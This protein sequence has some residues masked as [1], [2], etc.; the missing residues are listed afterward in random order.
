MDRLD[1]QLLQFETQGFVHLPGVIPPELVARVK[2]AF[3]AGAERHH[4]EWEKLP[5]ERRA[6]SSYYDIPDILDEDDAFVDLAD[7]SSIMP[8][9]LKAVGQDIQLNHTHA[10]IMFPGKTFTAAWHSDLEQLIGVDLAHSPHF[11]AKVHFYF[12]DL[13]PEQGCLGFLPGT[14]F[15][16]ATVN[17]RPDPDKVGGSHAAVRIVPKAGDAVLFN[18]H[19]RHM[20]FDNRTNKPRKSL[21][22]AYSH[23]WLKNYANAVPRD[24][25]RVATTPLRQQLFGVE[26]EGVSYFDQ[27][28]DLSEVTGAY[29][30]LRSVGKRLLKRVLKGSSVTKVK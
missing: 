12:E 10:R 28:L 27:R 3:D 15:L 13:D 22:Y 18:V 4:A 9:L 20:A 23:F 5:A 30:S 17:P 6:V 14:H 7:L 26:T 1:E 25:D 21:I 24:L 19:V 16:P 29:N 11:F 8:L 2:R